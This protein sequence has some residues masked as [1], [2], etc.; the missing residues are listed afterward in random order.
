L[1]L[2]FLSTF[3]TDYMLVQT[4]RL[5]E[6]MGCVGILTCSTD[7]NRGLNLLLG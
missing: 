4:A 3:D 5:E 6:A 7:R 1:N 2:L